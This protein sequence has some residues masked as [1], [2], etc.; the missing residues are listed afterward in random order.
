MKLNY[1]TATELA[2]KLKRKTVKAED[3]CRDCL[4]M[5][6]SKD[7]EIKAWEY[8][9]E[10][11]VL[12]YAREIDRKK[13][14]GALRGIPVGVKDIFNTKDM[15]TAMGSPIWKDFTP[16][17]DARV[18]H[19]IRMNDGIV[20]GK[21]VTAEF[22]VHHLPKDKTKN[23]HN[24]KHSPGTSSSGSAAAVASCMIPLA[25]GT[26]TAGSTIRPASYCGIFG[27]KPTF[28][29]VPRTG[30][31]KTTDTLDTVGCFARSVDDI[32]MIFDA[33]RVKGRDY[34]F[35]NAHL[36][37]Y[38][39]A[40]NLENIRIGI[41]SE[42]MGVFDKFE[43]HLLGQFDKYVNKLSRV[44]GMS[45][46]RIRP[47]SNLNKIHRIHSVLYDKTLSY[48]FK[49]EFNH[50]T[51]ISDIMYGIIKR[52]NK[53]SL[54]EYAKALKEQARLRIVVE[55]ELEGHDLIL[56]PSTSGEPPLAGEIENPDT[57]LIWTFLGRPALNIPAFR[58]PRN[59]P[60][61]LQAVAKK[62]DDYKLLA[63]AGELLV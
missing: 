41:L 31:L 18:V 47:S 14:P 54:D 56:T 12:K 36:K 45:V 60:M 6:A 28:G 63:I 8:I 52:G 3:V 53:I 58:G 35:V 48:Y 49:E 37:E 46:T 1:L 26:Q 9:D 20:F 21:T 33:I 23:P 62:Y 4:K 24:L 40:A 7:K 22:A 13:R 29:T 17:N 57:C 50:K 51:L 5:V 10:D 39:R 43:D 19:N 15:P 27:F 38:A 42:G 44:K 2:G 61:G 16:G 30:M 11:L 32:R 34:P 59:L 55:K 25:L